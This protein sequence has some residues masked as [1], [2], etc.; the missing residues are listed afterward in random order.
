[1]INFDDLFKHF[2]GIRKKDFEKILR[3][4]LEEGTPLTKPGKHGARF[5]LNSGK[6]AEIMETYGRILE[7]RLG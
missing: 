1:M 4:M 6:K 2:K 7:D 5:S 3:E